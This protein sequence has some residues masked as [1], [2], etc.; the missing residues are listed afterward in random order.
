MDESGLNSNTAKGCS[1]AENRLRW[2]FISHMSAAGCFGLNSIFGAYIGLV[3]MLAGQSYAWPIFIALALE[4]GLTAYGLSR[5]KGWA[6]ILCAVNFMAALAAGV[7]LFRKSLKGLMVSDPL[8]SGI[9]HFGVI[10]GLLVM[11]IAML[12]LIV[13]AVVTYERHLYK[14]LADGNASRSPPS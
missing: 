5:R 14:P 12:L 10:L 3:Y 11:L 1:V 4:T 13:L 9:S 8:Y 2:L 6:L 7:W